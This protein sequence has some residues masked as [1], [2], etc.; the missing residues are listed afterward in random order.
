M[1]RDRAVRFALWVVLAAVGLGVGG[2]RAPAATPPEWLPRYDLA[3][4]VEPAQHAVRVRE[5]IVCHGVEGY[6]EALE[7]LAGK[8]VATG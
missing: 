3:I 7:L 4:R 1:H 8:A 2:N 5:R 6:R